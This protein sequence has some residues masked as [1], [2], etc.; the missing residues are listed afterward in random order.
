YI[1][2]IIF[3]SFSFTIFPDLLE[4]NLSYSALAII[5]HIV[6]GT[7]CITS[8][9]TGF[10]YISMINQSVKKQGLMVGIAILPIALFVGLIYL[11]R[12]I[13]SPVIHFGNMGSLV[14]GG[15]T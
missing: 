4:G 6:I 2:L 1:F 14:I 12:A 10:K 5:G 13:N 3:G 15:I 9:F 11:N 8:V 7:I